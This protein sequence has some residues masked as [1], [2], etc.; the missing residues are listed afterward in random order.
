[1][2]DDT[3]DPGR[4]SWV[5]SAGAADAGFPIQNLPYCAFRPGGADGAARIGVGIGDRILDLASA[6]HAGLLDRAGGE[7]ISACRQPRLNELMAAGPETWRRLRRTL[8]DLLTTGAQAEERRI[9]AGLLVDRDAAELRLPAEIGDFTDFFAS[10]YHAT[11][12]GRLFRPETPLLPNY[13]WVPVAYHGRSSSIGVS[14]TP[15]RRP[16]GQLK[17][18]DA[19]APVFAPARRLDYEA[20][21]GFFVGPG[22][23]LG[24]P[25]PVGR[26]ARH[27]FGVA[28]LNDWSARDIQAWEYQ[29]LGPFLAKSFASTLSPWVVTMDALAPFHTAAAERPPDD[30][31]PLPYLMDE[32]DQ[33]EGG[34]DVRVGVFIETAAM[35][36]RGDE[37]HLLSWSRFADT[38]WT[39]AQFV[40]HHTSNGCNLRPGDLLGS[41]TVS[42]REDG[43]SG[44]MI[45]LTRGGASP[46]SLPGGETRSFLEDGDTIILRAAAEREGFVPIDFGECRARIEAAL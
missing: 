26:A 20:E 28:L 41:G 30:P 12:V 37:P 31:R 8:S 13:K 3:H 36:A 43:A 46:L 17:P 29:P 38:Y 27:L 23:R 33:V 16:R 45:E 32:D 14:G 2:L 11:N 7:A 5:E 4:R 40:A 10:V 1:M 18:P 19:D 44:C 6:A 21:L 35:R 25:V 22:N 39:P 9:A 24:E 34:L 42:S 15:V